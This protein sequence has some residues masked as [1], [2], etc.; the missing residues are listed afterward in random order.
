[1]RD[2]HTRIRPPSEWRKQ[3]FRLF[4][5]LLIPLGILLPRLAAQHPAFI[6]NVFSKSVYPVISQVLGAVFSIVPFSLAEWLLY[7]SVLAIVVAIVSGFVRLLMRKIHISAFIGIFI[8]IAIAGGALL[9]IFYFAWGFNYSRFTLAQTLELDVHARDTA[10][11]N[12]L[13]VSL[14][15]TAND[16]RAQVSEDEN[17]VFTY[18]ESVQDV[19]KQIPAAYARMEEIT[20]YSFGTVYVPKTVFASE[21]L[22]YAGISG[23]YFPF[24]AECNVNINQPDLYLASSAAHET[25]HFSGIA[26]ENEANFVSYLACISS[27]DVRIRYSGTVMALVHAGNQLSRSD[28]EAYR[29]LWN[30]YCDGLV[31]DLRDYSAYVQTYEGPVNET[32]TQV[33]DQYLKYNQQTSGVKSYG[34]MV[35]LLLAYYSSAD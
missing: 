5:L 7:L 24:T 6:E 34:E 11:L 13:C 25:A 27:E 23:I 29:A 26:R 20:G 21:G 12:E 16:L 17:G 32:M 19:F 9:N 18:G 10:E 30:T 14:A 1:M 8:S 31:R 15:R 3:L 28:P 35:D 4:W 2:K 22:S 33:N